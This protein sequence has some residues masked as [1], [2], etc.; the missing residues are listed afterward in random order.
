[1]LILL[2]LF[3]FTFCKSCEFIFPMYAIK[4]KNKIGI[5]IPIIAGHPSLNPSKIEAPVNPKG[6]INPVNPMGSLS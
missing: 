5:P 4:G 1:M 6:K 3:T 2:S